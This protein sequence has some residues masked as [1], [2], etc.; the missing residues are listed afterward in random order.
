MVD[1]FPTGADHPDLWPWSIA[2]ELTGATTGMVALT[3][4]NSG[5]PVQPEMPLA[6]Y[7][8]GTLAAA[9][10]MAELRKARL[11]KT[12]PIHFPVATHEAV[13]RAIEWQV[14]VAAVLGRPEPRIGNRFPAQRRRLQH[15]PHQRRQIRCAV[16][17]DAG[18]RQPAVDHDRRRALDR[19]E[20]FASPQARAG[21][22]S[23]LYQIIDEWIAQRTADETFD[24]AE[25]ADVVIGPI[26]SV[27]DILADAQIAARDNVMNSERKV[28]MPAV[29]PSISSVKPNVPIAAPTIG[30]HSGEALDFVGYSEAEIERMKASR[31]I[32]NDER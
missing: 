3:G 13:Q 30:Q 32:W 14:P 15:A 24:A 21:N 7:L 27:D 20:R 31:L 25:D 17:G 12:R 22:M 29:L 16:G 10:A 23:A 8:A 9:G 26:Y 4:Y 19:D 18:C 2:P 1:L 28:P 6:E 11:A 5:P